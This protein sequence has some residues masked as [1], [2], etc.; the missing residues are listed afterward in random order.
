MYE[1][2]VKSQRIPI[3]YYFESQYHVVSVFFCTA[4]V[5][6]VTILSVCNARKAAERFALDYRCTSGT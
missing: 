5:I 4:D 1:E 3:F 2:A 6:D